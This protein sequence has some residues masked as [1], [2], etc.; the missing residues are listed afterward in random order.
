VYGACARCSLVST[1][2]LIAK[3]TGPERSLLNFVSPSS[4][5]DFI[6]PTPSITT[7]QAHTYSSVRCRLFVELH[8][9]LPAPHPRI[10]PKIQRT[11][12]HLPAV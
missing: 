3:L 1:I 5:Q 7:S 12:L 4:S 9:K 10:R 11:A 8:L 2:S 6:H